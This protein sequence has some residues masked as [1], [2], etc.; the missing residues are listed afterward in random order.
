MKLFTSQRVAHSKVDLRLTG[1][2]PGQRFKRQGCGLARSRSNPPQST[3]PIFVPTHLKIG[4]N[5]WGVRIATAKEEGTRK[6]HK[7]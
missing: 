5:F 7:R 4:H 1:G 6:P 3:V 2:P